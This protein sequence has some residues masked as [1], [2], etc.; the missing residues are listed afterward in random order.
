MQALLH[1]PEGEL[2]GALPD[3]LSS[4]RM[5]PHSAQE[6][7]DRLAVGM[8]LQA[9]GEMLRSRLGKMLDVAEITDLDAAG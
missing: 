1:G 3:D 2:R 5:L 9:W 6:L 8:R 4:L 7:G